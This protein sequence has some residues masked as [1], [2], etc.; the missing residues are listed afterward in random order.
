MTI[1]IVLDSIADKVLIGIFPKEFFFTTMLQVKGIGLQPNFAIIKCPIIIFFLSCNVPMTII[2]LLHMLQIGAIRKHWYI[3]HRY[4][5]RGLSILFALDTQPPPI[6]SS[7]PKGLQ[8]HSVSYEA[9]YLWPIFS[10]WKTDEGMGRQMLN[11]VSPLALKRCTSIPDTFDVTND[12]V[13]QFLRE[14][15]SL[16]EEMQVCLW[17][18]GSTNFSLFKGPSSQTCLIL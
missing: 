5:L 7:W 14:G 11:G 2:H 8:S 6:Q 13:Y 18:W 15:K 1:I 16:Q 17:K 3:Y 4:I 10:S 9:N 12:D